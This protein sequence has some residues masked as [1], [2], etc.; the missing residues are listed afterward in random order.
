M[1]GPRAINRMSG[2]GAGISTNGVRHLARLDVRVSAWTARG[3]D[4]FLLMT[5]LRVRDF[6]VNA[7]ISDRRGSNHALMFGWGRSTLLLI[8]CRWVFPLRDALLNRI[9]RIT[10]R[11]SK[12]RPR[13]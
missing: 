7:L 2:Q 10:G 1:S 3:R 11:S 8:G 13:H 12:S 4:Y 6:C 5:S 9:V